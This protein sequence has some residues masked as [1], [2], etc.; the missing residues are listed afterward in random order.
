MYKTF[1]ACVCFMQ[2]WAGKC[3]AAATVGAAEDKEITQQNTG[4]VQPAEK[5]TIMYICIYYICI[6][7]VIFVFCELLTDP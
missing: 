5:A 1:A 4:F 2:G 6:N 7:K 3:F